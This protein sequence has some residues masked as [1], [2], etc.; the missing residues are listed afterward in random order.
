[1]LPDTSVRDRDQVVTRRA[2][3]EARRSTE[4]SSEWDTDAHQIAPH[5]STIDSNLGDT[6]SRENVASHNILMV[7]QLWLWYFKSPESGIPD[8]LITSFPSREGVEMMDPGAVDDLQ[9]SV[10][11]NQNTHSRDPI[12]TSEELISRI[13]SVCCRTLDR[14]QQLK[15]V[16]FLQMFQSMIGDAVRDIYSNIIEVFV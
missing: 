8:T 6:H 3:K 14:H 9:A 11:R 7:D 10:L 5:P 12:L 4:E 2:R 16:E 1:M 15:S 13:I